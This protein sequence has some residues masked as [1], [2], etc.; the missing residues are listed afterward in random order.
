MPRKIL[1][2]T[3]SGRSERFTSH[4]YTG[5]K[6]WLT[7]PSGNLMAAEALRGCAPYLAGWEIVVTFREFHLISELRREFK[8][9]GFDVSLV[10][11]TA[12]GGRG[13]DVLNALERAGVTAADTVCVRDCDNHLVFDPN[14]DSNGVVLVPNGYPGF[15][16]ESS[17]AFVEDASTV[18]RLVE[19]PH[20]QGEAFNAR[21][22]GAYVFNRAKSLVDVLTMDSHLTMAEALNELTVAGDPVSAIWAQ[23]YEDWGTPEAWHALKRRRA[24]WFVDLDGLLLRSTHRSFSIAGS[25]QGSNASLP[26]NVEELRQ[27]HAN[28]AHVVITTAR[29]EELRQVTIDQLHHEGIPYHQLVMGLPASTPR[30]LVNDVVRSRGEVGARAIEVD[31]NGCF[32]AQTVLPREASRE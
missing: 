31:R 6:A 14:L 27:L 25:V 2:L 30:V 13:A 11:I 12:T 4:G 20:P 7:H 26:L 3:C 9:A 22:A 18:T 5:Q 28:G 32:S 1:L 29:N 23:G 16:F 21:C 15:P 19:R 17:A 10:Y 24:T 8:F